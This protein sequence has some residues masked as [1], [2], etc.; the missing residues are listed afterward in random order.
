MQLIHEPLSRRS[1]V[2]L[3]V[4]GVLGSALVLEL[5]IRLEI[6]TGSGLPLP[7]AVADQARGLLGD[8]DFWSQILYTL[9][10]W[11]LGLAIASV[12]GV[13]LGGLMGASRTVF[14][15]FALTVEIL[16][17]LPAIAVGPLLVL[18]IGDGMLPLAVTVAIAC[19]WPILFNS[20]YA[21]KAVDPVA[22]QTARTLHVSP[23]GILTRIRLP[24]ALPFMFTGIRVA[25]S[26]GLIV[27]VSAEL[28][29]GNG[30]GIGGYILLASTSAS[31]LDAVYA[32]TL[33]AGVMGV[34][35]SVLFA[36]ADRL[37]FGW[38]AGL[39]P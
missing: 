33:V 29:L 2:V 37:L 19:T 27:A 34:L 13:V 17:P 24:A 5:L 39:A 9:R 26:I 10:E 25:A 22:I 1:E 28:L 32:A 14:K 36:V 30:V 12:A 23:L 35:V 6:V 31:N 11:M 38:K 7:S 3:G 8:V 16:R 21:A 20:M 15:L 18:L 4:A